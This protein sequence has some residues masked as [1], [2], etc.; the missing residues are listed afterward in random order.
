ME[1]KQENPMANM[2]FPDDIPP[3]TFGGGGGS[4]FDM[5]GTSCE[6][7]GGGGGDKWGSLGFM[8]LLGIHQDFVAPSL[9]D[10]FNHPP[11]LLPPP[12]PSSV[13]LAAVFHDHH[14]DV[15]LNKL[16]TNNNNKQ[17]N[18]HQ[19]SHLSP[20][21]STVPEYSEVLN[22]PAT[23]NSSSISSSSNEVTANDERNKAGDHDNEYKTKKPLKPKKNNQKRQK[24]PR[25][26]FITKSEIDHLDDG[27]R[28]RKYGQKAVKNS[29]YP[30]SYYRCTT[31][32][33]GVKKRVERSSD[34]STTVVTTYE[35]QHT[36]PCPIMPRGT[37]GFAIDSSSFSSPSSFVVTQ[38]RYLHHQPQQ[39]QPYV[40]TSSPSLN[41]T[42]TSSNSNHH[43]SFN[44]F[45]QDKPRFNNPNSSALALRD[46]GLLQDIVLTPTRRETKEE[47]EED[48]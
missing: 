47:E 14:H 2:R 12:P 28:W 20:V 46:H 8:D 1:K 29:P 32:G 5:A 42:T 27:Y 30:R 9:F 3:S 41:I 39:L 18:L 4:I 33:C 6:G 35:G 44:A 45:F 26:A 23:P 43:P 16:D 34:E 40:Y 21:A 15:L 31:A 36:H 10:S 24:Q 17:Q 11:V 13:E 38:P 22:N 19:G 48:Q 37:I 7:S 25:F